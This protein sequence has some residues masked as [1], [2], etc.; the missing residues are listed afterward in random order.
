MAT[1]TVPR[2]RE[3]Q[4]IIWE[5]DPSGETQYLIKPLSNSMQ[6]HIAGST[7]FKRK[8]RK[9]VAEGGYISIVTFRIGLKGLKGV[10]DF[11][12][13]KPLELKF[14]KIK[15]G[16]RKIE[17]VQEEIY[18]L[19]PANLMSDILETI[20]DASD[21]G[22]DEEEAVDFTAGSSTQTSNA[23]LADGTKASVDTEPA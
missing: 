13:G 2:E 3:G 22:E 5:D 9:V 23:A 18:D 10:I 11:D 21:F 4:W 20:Q 6:T 19:L 14:A 8:G 1:K 12:T 16:T 7:P 15:V 17:A